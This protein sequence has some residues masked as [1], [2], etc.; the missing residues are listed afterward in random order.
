MHLVVVNNIMPI[1]VYQHQTS[2][3]IVFNLSI[4]I[5]SV[6]DVLLSKLI[7]LLC[8][9]SSVQS[10]TFFVE[11]QA[12]CTNKS[13]YNKTFRGYIESNKQEKLYKKQFTS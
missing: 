1:V 13:T 11:N 6:T 4:I 5:N 9:N 12:F 7:I 8:A 10:S 2:T 3:E